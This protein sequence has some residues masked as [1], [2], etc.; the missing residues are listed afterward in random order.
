[1]AF[2]CSDTKNSLPGLDGGWYA[3]LTE[4]GVQMIRTSIMAVGAALVIA[5]VGSPAF[6]ASPTAK[7][8]ASKEKAAGAKIQNKLTCYGKAKARNV[9]VDDGCLA[10]AEAKFTGAVTKA[11][12]KGACGGTALD[13]ENTV[14]DCI[15][16]LLADIP[17]NTRCASTS[18]KG[19]GKAG[20]C[21]LACAAKDVV[22]PGILASCHL[23]CDARLNSTLSKAGGCGAS[24][25]IIAHV[26]D[27]RDTIVATF[28]SS[29]TSSTIATTTSSSSSTSTSS[30]TSSTTSSTAPS[31]PS[32]AFVD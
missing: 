13:L 28:G 9:A 32:S 24:L 26:H 11:D 29:T 10:K 7:C 18:A 22:K 21:E 4:G 8:V 5:A 6:A 12:S 25:T 15:D 17:G 23:R 31:S 2:A 3:P 30:S 1:M 19:E 16:T 14:D 27:C 20:G